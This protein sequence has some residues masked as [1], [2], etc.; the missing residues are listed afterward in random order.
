MMDGVVTGQHDALGRGGVGHQTTLEAV[1]KAF[2]RG[3]K[4][5]KVG[6]GS[7]GHDEA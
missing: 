3:M 4:G 1:A 7:R 5:G 6:E 2:L